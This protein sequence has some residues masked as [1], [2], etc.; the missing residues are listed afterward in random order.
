MS[1]PRI[2]SQIA[3]LFFGVA[4]TLIL[5]A[6]V[7]DAI[8]EPPKGG[9]I[10]NQPGSCSTGALN[11]V[12]TNAR[13][14]GNRTEPVKC[15]YQVD[16]TNQII[17]FSASLY[18][19][20]QTTD[21]NGSATLNPIKSN[22][23]GV[24]VVATQSR[25][26]HDDPNL[27][28]GRTLEFT[29]DYWAAH[30]P[31]GGPGPWSHDSGTVDVFQTYYGTG[32]AYITLSGSARVSP[33]YLVVP[34]SVIAQAPADFR[35]TTDVDTNAYDFAWRVDGSAV[36]GNND[37][38]LTTTFSLPGTHQVTAFATNSA[39]GVDSITA[40][41]TAHLNITVNGPLTLNKGSGATYSVT[42]GAGG[43]TPYTYQW[44]KNG[45]VVG[46]SATYRYAALNCGIVVLTVDVTDSG[47]HTGTGQLEV[48]TTGGGCPV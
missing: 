31:A 40:T 29:G 3:W 10:R 8:T 30:Y 12:W 48:E 28:T 26:W 42:I 9:G 21:P 37:A 32:S 25:Y 20:K 35:A 1:N 19:P 34:P 45:S 13:L 24:V 46:T 39:G 17:V 15:P 38:R 6:C 5:S 33:G 27:S 47:G 41:V 11:T 43:L 36:T 16:Y 44:R 7:G 4:T 23:D 14:N 2:G 22:L 18:G